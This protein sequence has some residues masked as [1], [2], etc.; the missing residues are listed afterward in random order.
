MQQTKVDKN[1]IYTCTIHA[2]IRAYRLHLYI[3]TCTYIYTHMYVYI[4]I[5]KSYVGMHGIGCER[6][7]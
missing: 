3:Y 1:Q 6:V 7:R 4:N 2:Y 5:Y